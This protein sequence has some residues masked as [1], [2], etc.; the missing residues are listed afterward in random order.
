MIDYSFSPFHSEIR[1][2]K[3]YNAEDFEGMRRAGKLAAQTLDFIEPH[4]R[5][6]V[7]T[8]Q[9][10]TLCHDL[11]TLLKSEEKEQAGCLANTSIKTP[12]IRA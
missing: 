4:I 10:N 3:I 7:S 8:E 2:V 11:D 9:L 6:G 1:K 5:P 12:I